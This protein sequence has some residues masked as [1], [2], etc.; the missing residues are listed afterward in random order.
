MRSGCWVVGPYYVVVVGLNLWFLT[1][2]P[3]AASRLLGIYPSY[4][5]KRHLPSHTTTQLV[6]GTPPSTFTFFLSKIPKTPGTWMVS[7]TWP[8]TTRRMHSL[9]RPPPHSA[10][11][12][13]AIVNILVIKLITKL[14]QFKHTWADMRWVG[15]RW[16][17]ALRYSKWDWVVRG[18]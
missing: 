2:F 17:V 10:K 9:S 7:N 1:S 13:L 11:A 16:S 14:F 4:F 15:L 3:T 6:S 12:K 5:S 18:T 8:A